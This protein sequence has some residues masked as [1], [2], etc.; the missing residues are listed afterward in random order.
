MDS[1]FYRQ[2]SDAIRER[3]RRYYNKTELIAAYREIYRAAGAAPA[4]VPK[5]SGVVGPRA[6]T[7]E[8]GP[9]P[10]SASR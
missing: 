3:V 6:A 5:G 1:A 2:C 9:W 4:E 10:A 7:R 8:E